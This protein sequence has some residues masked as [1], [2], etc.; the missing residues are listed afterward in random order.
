MDMPPAGFEDFLEIRERAMERR[1]HGPER[2]S[3]GFRDLLE[4]EPFVVTKHDDLLLARREL[5]DGLSHADGVLF[6]DLGVQGVH[7]GGVVQIARFPF[8]GVVDGPR[9]APTL[10]EHVD[11][12]V[13]DDAIGPGERRSPRLP[14]GPAAVDLDECLLDGI[15]RLF[16]VA[17]VAVGDAKE[18]ALV[19]L[20]EYGEG[21]LI[22]FLDARHESGISRIHLSV[23]AD[24]VAPSR[25]RRPVERH[26]SPIGLPAWLE[27]RRIRAELSRGPRRVTPRRPPAGVFRG[28]TRRHPGRAASA[29]IPCPRGRCRAREPK[30][31]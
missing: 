7:R 25:N 31:S 12:M 30:A 18:P 24:G 11:A 20:D 10:P 14:T 26:R 3:L 22:S 8:L 4:R 9:V 13:G 28:E 6:L 17:K 1:L 15:E 23:P 16:L 27:S 2:A 29:P 21:T 19:A 5:E